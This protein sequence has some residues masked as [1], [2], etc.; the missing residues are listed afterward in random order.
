MAHIA[1]QAE[2]NIRKIMKKKETREK[3]LYEQLTIKSRKNYLKKNKN[4]KLKGMSKGIRVKV[5][6]EK[7]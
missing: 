4:K 6:E 3:N 2:I 5:K 7:K 1:L